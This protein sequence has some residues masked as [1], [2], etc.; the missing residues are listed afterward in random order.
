MEEAL[1]KLYAYT[2]QPDTGI[3]HPL[4][5]TDS[6]YVPTSAESLY[7]LV[8]CSALVNYIKAIKH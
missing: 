2:N 7:M 1:I 8:T 3:R 4:M 6:D 5:E